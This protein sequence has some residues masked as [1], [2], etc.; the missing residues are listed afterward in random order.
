MVKMETIDADA[1]GQYMENWPQ[2]FTDLWREQV[3]CNLPI[4]PELL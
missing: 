4:F 1:E 2:V 3:I